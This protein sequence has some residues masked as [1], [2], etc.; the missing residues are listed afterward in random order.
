MPPVAPATLP[1]S[2]RIELPTNTQF[3]HTDTPLPTPELQPEAL[4]VNMQSCT[5]TTL[6]AL[7]W[8]APCEPPSFTQF[9]SNQQFDTTPS[10]LYSAPP[11]PV[12]MFPTN[13]QP[14]R[15]RPF[16]SAPPGL[17]VAALYL[18]VQFVAAQ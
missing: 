11:F 4:F 7:A 12:P 2:A 1:D 13:V 9:D 17:F 3:D 10:W 18:N 15:A 5:T 14:I 6:S 8:I 16:S